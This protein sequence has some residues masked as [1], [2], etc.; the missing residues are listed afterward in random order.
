MSIPSTGRSDWERRG[1]H[2][3]PLV[4]SP[5][6]ACRLLGC[7]L[8]RFYEILPELDS[9]LEGSVRRI[10]VDSIERRVERK[11]AEAQGQKT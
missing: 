7:G 9:Y 3:K 5:R 2:I 10:T 1:G 8:T 11:L 6:E 4:V